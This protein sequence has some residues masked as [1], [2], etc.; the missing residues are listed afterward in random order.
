MYNAIERPALS[1]WMAEL[2]RTGDVQEIEV[3]APNLVGTSI[4]DLDTYLSDGVLVALV[5]R[6]GESQIPE[7]NLELEH[8]D[9]LT[10]VVMLGGSSAAIRTRG[11][12]TIVLKA[13]SLTT[14]SL[15]CE[16]RI[17]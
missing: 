11:T 1:E 10:F 16:D 3:T 14:V 17:L 6:N 12:P 2:G 5:S 15:Y 4:G 8:G 7:A 9:H 13:E